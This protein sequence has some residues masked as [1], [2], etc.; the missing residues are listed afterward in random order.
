MYYHQPKIIEKWWLVTWLQWYSNLCV[1]NVA[2]A[3]VPAICPVIFKPVLTLNCFNRS[4]RYWPQI[5]LLP[6]WN[7][8]SWLALNSLIPNHSPNHSRKWVI[9]LLLSILACQYLQLKGQLWKIICIWYS[10]HQT[11]M[12]C[13]PTATCTH[14]TV[15]KKES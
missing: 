11:A 5:R 15:L 7:Y 2:K 13:S 8:D 14:E 10:Q 9:Y 12:K 6:T 4:F 1:Y 3:S